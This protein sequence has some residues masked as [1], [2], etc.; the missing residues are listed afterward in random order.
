MMKTHFVVM[1]KESERLEKIQLERLKE[2]SFAILRKKLYENQE[3]PFSSLKKGVI[4]T[5]PETVT[6]YKGKDKYKTYSV[7]Y[8]IKPL[9][10][11][12]RKKSMNTIFWWKQNLPF[13]PNNK[14]TAIA[15]AQLFF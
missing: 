13:F 4:G 3:I 8:E 1:K 2:S 12:L 11:C 5:L 10:S 7:H 9:E 14:R 15:F 6:V